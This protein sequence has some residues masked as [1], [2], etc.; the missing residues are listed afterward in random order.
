MTDPDA[1]SWR[2]TFEPS[3]DFSLSVRGEII[4]RVQRDDTK[5]TPPHW[6]WSINCVRQFV[7]MT[8]PCKTDSGYC[9]TKQETGGPCAPHGC[10]NTT[11]APRCGSCPPTTTLG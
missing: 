2:Y 1:G 5:A 3:P 11:G 6:G 7:G 8:K 10:W 9:E 4:G